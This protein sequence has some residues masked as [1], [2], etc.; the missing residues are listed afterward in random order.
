M[1]FFYLLFIIL[2]PKA[3]DKAVAESSVNVSTLDSA[4]FLF[5][6]PAPSSTI[7]KSLVVKSAPISEPPSISIAA[8]GRVP[9]SPV[10]IKVP[11][12]VGS[13]NT[14]LLDAE[15]GAACNVCACAF[16]LSQ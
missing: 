16:E 1:K 3:I 5:V 14:A 6:P 10:P 11:D 15:C 8:R 4:A 9:V 2:Y 13:T 7:I 12:A